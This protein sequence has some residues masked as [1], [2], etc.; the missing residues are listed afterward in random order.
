MIM[1]SGQSYSC[2]RIPCPGTSQVPR[3]HSPNQLEYLALLIAPPVVLS[4]QQAPISFDF[5][6]MV[7]NVLF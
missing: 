3:F 4:P 7:Q 6:T 2:S 1:G 5:G